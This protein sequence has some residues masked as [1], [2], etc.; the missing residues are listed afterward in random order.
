MSILDDVTRII[1]MVRKL[2]R[3][4]LL[5]DVLDELLRL[6]EKIGDLLEE[7]RRLRQ[8]LRARLQPEDESIPYEGIYWFA[9]RQ[10]GLGEG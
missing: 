8:R 1:E 5:D 10:F 4:N 9:N 2:D 7:N 6:R 3:F